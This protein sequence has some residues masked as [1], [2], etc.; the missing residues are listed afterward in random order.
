PVLPAR[1]PVYSSRENIFVYQYIDRN[2]PSGEQTAAPLPS[3]RS[4][5][6]P[7]RFFT[8]KIAAFYRKDKIKSRSEG[9][10]AFP[11]IQNV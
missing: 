10:Q 5:L 8:G 6:P 4:L 11:T 9:I 1:T 3:L 7:S 2:P